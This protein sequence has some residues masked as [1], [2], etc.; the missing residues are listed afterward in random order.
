M[1]F[2]SDRSEFMFIVEYSENEMI[3]EL[4]NHV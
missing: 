2:Y 1:M 3:V 4:I